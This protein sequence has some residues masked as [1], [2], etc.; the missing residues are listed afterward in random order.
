M[1]ALTT[2]QVPAGAF[3]EIVR[4]MRDGRSYAN[5][6]TT[7]SPGGEIRGQVKGTGPGNGNDNDN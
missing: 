2:Q 4:V 7:A 1:V 3:D 5:V 6:H